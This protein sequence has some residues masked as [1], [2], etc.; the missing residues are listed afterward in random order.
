MY[1]DI[2]S[3]LVNIESLFLGEGAMLTDSGK[4]ALRVVLQAI[5]TFGYECAQDEVSDWYKPS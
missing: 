3:D 4:H 1:T 5:F 2:D